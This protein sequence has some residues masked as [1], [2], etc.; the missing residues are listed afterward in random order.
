MMACTIFA[1]RKWVEAKPGLPSGEGGGAI[2]FTVNRI[3]K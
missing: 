1:Q 2:R 3:K